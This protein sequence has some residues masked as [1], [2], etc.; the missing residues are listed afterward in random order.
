[1]P[2]WPDDLLHGLDGPRPLPATLHRRLEDALVADAP[3]RPL[4]D[5][6]SARLEDEL[7]DPLLEA[8]AGI[9][10]PRP[11][12][13]AARRAVTGA[14]TTRPRRVLPLVGAAAAVVLLAGTGLGLAFT[15]GAPGGSA[16]STHAAA[17]Q[18]ARSAVT[19]P[20]A[21]DLL[22]PSSTV[23]GGNGSPNPGATSGVAAGP[24]QLAT[25]NASG[26]PNTPV[27]NGVT[28]SSGP[29][30]GGTWVTVTGSGFISVTAVDFGATP[31]TTFVVVSPGELRA[32]VPPH[33]S[34]WVDVTVHVGAASSEPNP[35]DR[36]T[37]TT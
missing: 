2:E 8:F 29:P 5:E 18:H 9:D 14:L 32:E 35:A 25:P 7:A 19:A 15:A 1:M 27:V 6:L 13:D 37:Y 10:A 30:G 24:T 17:M 34:G 36:F 22:T 11:L 23:A 16:G 21:P 3:A 33:A 12:P 4:G 28:P 26:A 31:A 20:V